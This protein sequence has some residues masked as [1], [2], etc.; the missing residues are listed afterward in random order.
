MV[1]TQKNWRRIPAWSFG[2]RKESSGKPYL[3]IL[4]WKF[5][6][7]VSGLFSLDWFKLWTDNLV[8]WN[9]LV[10][11]YSIHSYL[12]ILHF[13]CMKRSYI[14]ALYTR[15]HCIYLITLLYRPR[16]SS[17]VWTNHNK[18]PS[19]FTNSQN[20]PGL[21][22]VSPYVDTHQPSNSPTKQDNVQVPKQTRSPPVQYTIEAS[23]E[24]F[25]QTESKR[26][27]VFADS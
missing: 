8:G 18:L 24:V 15:P 5:H 4:I 17:P 23:P 22:S 16:L 9:H 2:G 26:Y 21:S 14:S 6:V 27:Y 19:H 3:G 12:F 10:I 7:L 13:S 25:T 20:Q 1:F 11:F